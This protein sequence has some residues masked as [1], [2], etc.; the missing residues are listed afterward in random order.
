MSKLRAIIQR[1]DLVNRE[2]AVI[3]GGTRQVV[4]VP[5][6]CVVFLRGEPVKL[7]MLQP[8]DLVK[9]AFDSRAGATVARTIEVEGG[10]ATSA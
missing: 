6:D 8:G 3:A 10:P 2:V 9:V 7:R 5:S 4:T 1:I